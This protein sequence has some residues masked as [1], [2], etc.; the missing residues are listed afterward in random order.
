MWFSNYT[1]E[2][3]Y[4][5]SHSDKQFTTN[6]LTNLLPFMFEMCL[7]RGFAFFLIRYWKLFSHDVYRRKA[8]PYESFEYD[9]WK[10]LMLTVFLI[11]TNTVTDHK[12]F[13]LFAE[14]VD[15]L[16]S[17]FCQHMYDTGINVCEFL[18][19]CLPAH[20]CKYIFVS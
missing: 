15:G 3:N 13:Q 4:E 1:E 5:A 12:V 10:L 17:N 16:I 11:T 2:V 8:S 18:W 7:W 6:V 9:L 20:L 14:Q 19:C